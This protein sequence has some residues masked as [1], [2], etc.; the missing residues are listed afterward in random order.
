VSFAHAN[1][2][3]NLKLNNNNKEIIFIIFFQKKM[4]EREVIIRLTDHH[5]NVYAGNNTFLYHPKD[6]EDKL[7]EHGE[8]LHRE[9]NHGLIS[10]ILTAYCKQLPLRI[11]PDD[12]QFCLQMV[13]NAMINQNKAL[14][15]KLFTVPSCRNILSVVASDLQYPELSKKLENMTTS[16]T[17]NERFTSAFGAKYT[18]TMPLIET[19]AN[20]N[21]M[22]TQIE[23]F[24]TSSASIPT[25]YVGIP[26]VI[27][28]GARE[29]WGELRVN[30][31]VLCNVVSDTLPINHAFNDWLSNTSTVIQY[32]LDTLEMGD[33]GLSEEREE[34]VKKFWKQ[35]VSLDDSSG[36]VK[37]AGWATC[38]APFDSDEAFLTNLG[39]PMCYQNKGYDINSSLTRTRLS[40]INPGYIEKRIIKSGLSPNCHVREDSTVETNFCFYIVAEQTTLKEELMGDPLPE[41]TLLEKLVVAIAI[42]LLSLLLLE[43]VAQKQSYF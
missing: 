14:Q 38:F 35:A 4:T 25:S 40:I 5:K 9:S 22:D 7:V 12:I 30:F 31:H 21:L 15:D 29:N 27:M 16:N 2:Q 20:A 39:F 17:I 34:A 36:I 18:T 13:I 26:E 8:R 43:K 28:H 23:K 41:Y 1:R 6:V 19:I 24:N 37:I 32:L 10:A 3:S 42:F 33:S 11:R